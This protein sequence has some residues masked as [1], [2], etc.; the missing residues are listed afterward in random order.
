MTKDRRGR[1]GFEDE[2]ARED[3][4]PWPGKRT[5]MSRPR[6]PATWPGKRSVTGQMSARAPAP[7][8]PQDAATR[9]V[10][11]KGTGS[12][13]D[14]KLT[15]SVG[16]YFSTD[17][18]AARVHEDPGSREATHEMGARAFAY[19]NDVFLGQGESGNDT[20][21]MAHEL[22]HVAQ[23]QGGGAQPQAKVMVGDANSPAE[24][25]ADAV[26]A[27]AT[28]GLL[29]PAQLLV[30]A[31]PSDS[32][33]LKSEF[34]AQLR[35]KVTAVADAELGPAETAIG[36]PYIAEMFTRYEGLPASNGESML[37]KWVPDL[38]NVKTA[39]AMVPPVLDRVRVGIRSWRESGKVPADLVEVEPTLANAPP[40]TTQ[41][42][43]KSLDKL[44]SDLGPGQPLDGSTVARMSA[45][46]GTDVS[47]ARV[48]TGQVA[49]AK[50]AEAGATAFAVGTN[51]VMAAHAPRPGSMIGDALLAHELA[52]VAQQKGAASDPVARKK[53]IGDESEAAE[54]NA[55]GVAARGLAPLAS[56]GAAFADVMQTGLQLQRCPDKADPAK[57]MDEARYQAIE[58][59]LA[60][61]VAQ[62]KAIV[63][64]GGTGDMTAIDTET[65]QLIAELRADFGIR[66]DKGQ[67]LDASVA[68]KEMR[69]L[70]G[71]VVVS[72]SSST[73]YVG[74]RLGFK[75]EFDFIP[76]GEGLQIDWRWTRPGAGSTYKFFGGGPGFK[77]RTTAQE[78]ELDTPF[79]GISGNSITQAGGMEVQANLY[80]G[81]AQVPITISTGFIAMPPHAIPHLE[82]VNAPARAVAGSY[83]DLGIG[84]WTPDLDHYRID[85]W[86]NGNQ[87]AKDNL[88]LHHKF[89]DPGDYTV[90]A[91]VYSI[92][93][94]TDQT[95]F[96]RSTRT[97]IE[98]L[99]DEQYG[100]KFLDDLESSPFRPKQ[101]GIAGVV[102][103][104]NTTVGEIKHRIDQGGTTQPYW[105]DRLKAQKRAP[106]QDQGA[107]AGLRHGK[108]TAG[109][110]DQD[111]S[112]L[113]QRAGHGRTR[114]ER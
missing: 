103:S 26:A 85:W 49:A 38:R 1:D 29:T 69:Q 98:V 67:I 89:G 52:H 75:L 35:D 64:G 34:I 24:T 22:T 45:L 63:E 68:N 97:N 39:Q 28:A 94:R 15:R 104:G 96:V 16:G 57:K 2:A 87:V 74:E 42:H 14:A 100:N 110:S 72:P 8:R 109:R 37:R 60:S 48:H 56:F 13:V 21:L 62:K 107:R 90:R 108:A 114:D 17:L 11:N 4:L 32:Q 101:V 61:L 106:R 25:E 40:P 70:N 88:G 10:E 3:E 65:D 78:I 59:R 36:C 93:R 46:V 86:I 92:D 50:A 91:D 112:R 9:A 113:V 47:A 81:G 12:P 95:T 53:P 33:M 111:R 18:S 105:K 79:W 77:D 5:A 27:K 6:G 23:Q 99:T 82:I 102:S 80:I 41:A 51:V 19:G 20:A 73:H 54:T 76:P 66:M 55:D 83:L 44:E 71:R 31:N 7:T 58:K 43:A 84:P 30:D